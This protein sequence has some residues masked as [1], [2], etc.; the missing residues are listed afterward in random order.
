M[1]A[2]QWTEG[3]RAFQKLYA[4]VPVSALLG[5]KLSDRNAAGC[6]SDGSA[7]A[8]VQDNHAGLSDHLF[9]LGVVNA[10][11][12]ASYGTVSDNS[13]GDIV[14]ALSTPRYVNGAYYA[15]ASP[16]FQ[17]ENYQGQH[18]DVVRLDP[19]SSPPGR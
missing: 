5:V 6:A 4:A 16:Y 19:E 3:D 11:G 12:E 14:V 7:F 8:L 2:Y 13:G 15:V 10:D 1:S 18:I 9:H 17:G